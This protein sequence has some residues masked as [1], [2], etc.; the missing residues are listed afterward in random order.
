QPLTGWSAEDFISR[1]CSIADM[2]HPDDY[3]RVA[4]EVM[5]AIE[6]G[7]NYAVEYRLF[8]RDGAEHWIWESGSAVCD[9][10]GVP[11]WI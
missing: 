3:Q 5:Q 10:N 4:A 2:Y 7:R 9:E 11:R 8:D 6:Q 1:R